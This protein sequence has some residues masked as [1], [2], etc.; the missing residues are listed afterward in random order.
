MYER[1]LGI[2]TPRKWWLVWLKHQF[3]LADEV[4]VQA[5][6][7]RRQNYLTVP[8]NTRYMVFGSLTVRSDP[9]TYLGRIKVAQRCSQTATTRIASLIWWCCR[10]R[11]QHQ[12]RVTLKSSLSVKE[13][14]PSHGSIFPVNYGFL[15]IEPGDKYR[16]AGIRTDSSHGPKN[17]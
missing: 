13:G 5:P 7:R 1:G 6:K 14:E 8:C 12:Y 17:K 15:K 10:R 9:A 4:R 11:F 3:G 16:V 2:S